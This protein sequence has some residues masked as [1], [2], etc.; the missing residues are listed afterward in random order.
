MQ[1][2]IIGQGNVGTHLAQRAR[3]VGHDV[4]TWTRHE[5]GPI[6]AAPIYIICVSDDA[7][8]SVAKQ[9]PATAVVAHTSGST[10]ISVLSQ[11]RRGVL[12]PMQ[13]FS[14]SKPLNWTQVPLFVEGDVLIAQLAESMQP[15]SVQPLSS[16][17]RL[18]LHIAAVWACNFANHCV[19]LG[20]DQMAEA[21]LDWQLLLPL[22]HETVDKLHHLHPREGQTGPARR[23][24]E[25]II[26]LHESV[27]PPHL[28][29]L[30]ELLSRSIQKS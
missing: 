15:L 24:D 22:I 20:A 9:L 25:R 10:S 14:K 8:A 12:Y 18:H 23:H 28:S 27:L 6:P 29:E 21:G 26:S 3:E 1:L 11:E 16:E 5:G 19:A 13:T 30:Y 2:T 7:I 4:Q 17:Q